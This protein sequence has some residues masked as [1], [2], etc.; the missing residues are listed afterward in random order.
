M[1]KQV[2]KGKKMVCKHMKDVN[3]YIYDDTC[4]KLFTTS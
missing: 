1:N 3:I 2:S 4:S